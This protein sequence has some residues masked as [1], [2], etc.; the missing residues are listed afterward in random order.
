MAATLDGIVE[1]TGAVFEVKFMLPLS[2]SKEAA[3]EKHMAQLQHNMWVTNA[4]GAVL[5]VI[6][7]GGKWVEITGTADQ[8]RSRQILT[9]D[10]PKHVCLKS[11]ELYFR[12]GCRDFRNDMLSTKPFSLVNAIPARSRAFCIAL[13][14][15]LETCRRSFS[16][17]TTVE[18]PT[19]AANASWDW[20]ISSKARAPRHWAGVILATFFVDKGGG[21]VYQ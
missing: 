17:S 2:F 19:P 5:S 4:T 16:K 12:R 18:S 8:V 7:G 6:T 11:W 10:H 3:A 14:A 9:H 21:A 20:V 15:S 1:G 13:I